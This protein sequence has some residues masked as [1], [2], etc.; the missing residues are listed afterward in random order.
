VN[1]NSNFPGFPLFLVVEISVERG[2][3]LFFWITG[4]SAELLELL[5]TLLKREKGGLSQI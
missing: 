5:E 3:R 4:T 1:S 2:V